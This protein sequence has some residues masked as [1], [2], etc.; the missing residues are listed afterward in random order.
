MPNHLLEP[1]TVALSQQR[2][3]ESKELWSHYDEARKRASRAPPFQA[4]LCKLLSLKALAFCLRAISSKRGCCHDPGEGVETAACR[5]CD[6]GVEGAVMV[7]VSGSKG[8][9]ELT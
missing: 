1:G 9:N 3:M 6:W 2:V 4:I 7:A 5:I 8:F